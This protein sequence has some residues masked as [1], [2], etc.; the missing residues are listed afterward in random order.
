MFGFVSVSIASWG[1]DVSVIMVI[2]TDN[3]AAHTRATQV[4]LYS[5]LLG[6]FWQLL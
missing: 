3:G 5:A 1:C 2:A 6:V 4:V